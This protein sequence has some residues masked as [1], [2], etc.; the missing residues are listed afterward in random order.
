MNN[1]GKL[2]VFCGLDG[3]GKTTQVNLLA[4]RLEKEMFSIYLTSEPTPWYLRDPLVQNYFAEGQIDENGL[5]ALALFSA[6]DR[7]RH[8]REA[9]IPNLN[10]GKMVISSRYVFSAYAYFFARGLRDQTW[11]ETINRYAIDPDLTFFLD[12]E[13]EVALSRISQ[14]GDKAKREE[15]NLSRI[16]EIR[17]RF[18]SFASDDFCVLDA[19]RGEDEL[20]QQIISILWPKLPSSSRLAFD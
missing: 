13:P 19:N 6:A 1:P 9:I 14:R 10:A 17:Q 12:L 2:F 15:M 20:H 4:R 7:A 5:A 11:L 3:S 18:L 16:R 8:V